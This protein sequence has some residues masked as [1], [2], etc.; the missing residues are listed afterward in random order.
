MSDLPLQLQGGNVS[1]DLLTLND[2]PALQEL[3]ER[4]AD[5]SWL[6]EGEPPSPHAAQDMLADLP[7]SKT[8]ADKFLYGIFREKTL[9]GVL[10]GIRGYPQ[11]GT[12]WI[13]LLLLDPAQR[14]RGTG[15][16]ALLAFEDWAGQQGAQALMLGVVEENRRGFNFW[17]RMGFT[18]VETR[19]PRRFGQKEQVVL[20]MR[21]EYQPPPPHVPASRNLPSA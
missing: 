10:D 20:V 1:L 4:C 2:A 9:V 3:L 15:E 18:L 6:V 5:F 11:E 19:P 16:Q 13:G 8:L 7:P 21:K 12:W 17:R 14:G